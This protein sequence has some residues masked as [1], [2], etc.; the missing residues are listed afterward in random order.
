MRS[1]DSKKKKIIK[2]F[3]FSTKPASHYDNHTQTKN[4]LKIKDEKGNNSAIVAA[5]AHDNYSTTI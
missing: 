3:I 1:N 5:V 4:K 2:C